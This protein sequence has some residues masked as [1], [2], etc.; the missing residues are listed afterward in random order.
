MSTPVLADQ[1]PRHCLYCGEVLRGRADKKYCSAECRNGFHNHHASR[2]DAFMREVNKSLRKNRRILAELAPEGKA[3]VHEDRL[4][5][6][7]FSFKYHTHVRRTKEGREYRFCY[8][9]G[10]LE[11]KPRWYVLVRRDAD[12]SESRAK[13]T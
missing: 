4:V 9:Y 6:R 2:N 11:F 1:T 5:D 7:G 3:N 10:Y 13:T 12:R 8:E